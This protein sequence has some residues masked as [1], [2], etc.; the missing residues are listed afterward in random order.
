MAGALARALTDGGAAR[1]LALIV[2]VGLAG[3]ILL[4]DNDLKRKKYHINVV[5]NY[6]YNYYWLAVSTALRRALVV[7]VA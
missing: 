7:A 4:D 5:R 1:A 3:V 2:A 6:K